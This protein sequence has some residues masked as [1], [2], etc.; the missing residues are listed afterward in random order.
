M[1]GEMEKV[2]MKCDKCKHNYQE[3][4]HLV[5]TMPNILILHMKEFRYTSEGHLIKLDLRLKWQEFLDSSKFV[6]TQAQGKVYELYALVQHSGNSQSGHYTCVAKR[7]HPFE[8]KKVWVNF[9]DEVSNIIEQ[10]QK[11][12]DD[13]YLLF[14]R[15]VDMPTSSLVIYS[16]LN[17][18]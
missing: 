7:K 9:D 18:K 4:E 15:K 17:D 8:N 12:I 6:V 1:Y 10:D 13:A 2:E 5:S 16:D 3:L 11:F 14:F